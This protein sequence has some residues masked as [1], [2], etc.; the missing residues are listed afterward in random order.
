METTTGKE[1]SA[2][3]QVSTRYICP[4]ELR[5][6]LKEHMAASIAQG[7]SASW[8]Y[9]KA[10]CHVDTKWRDA[11]V[12]VR[13]ERQKTFYY[14]EPHHA[15]RKEQMRDRL[16]KIALEARKAADAAAGVVTPDSEY[17]PRRAGRP[18][19]APSAT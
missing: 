18:A 2:A 13:Q 4:P 17:L 7:F 11:H 10:R 16:R 12:A 6:A 9:V 15:A 5:E 19:N 3:K 8:A 14:S 1:P